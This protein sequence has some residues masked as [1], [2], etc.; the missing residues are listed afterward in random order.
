MMQGT[1]RLLT[2]S[3]AQAAQQLHFDLCFDRAFDAS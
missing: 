3:K 1:Q 2:M